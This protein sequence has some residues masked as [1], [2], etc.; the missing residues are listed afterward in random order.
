MKHFVGPVL[1]S[2]Y[3]ILNEGGFIS[4]QT[5]QTD[6]HGSYRF[7]SFFDC[8]FFLEPQCNSY[9]FNPSNWIHLKLQNLWAKR[10]CVCIP[11][12]E[13]QSRFNNWASAW[14]TPP[15]WKQPWKCW[16][17]TPQLCCVLFSVWGRHTTDKKSWNTT[18]KSCVDFQTF[19]MCLLENDTERVLSCSVTVPEVDDAWNMKW[20]Y[21]IVFF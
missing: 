13:F 11:R 12:R 17:S 18:K 3:C 9:R 6:K 14:F 2:R 19:E 4:G 21:I 16:K 7:C 5:V 1:T 8:I 20:L 15:G 10:I